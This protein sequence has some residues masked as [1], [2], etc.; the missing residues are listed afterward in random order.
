MDKFYSSLIIFIFYVSARDIF[1]R[2]NCI[3]CLCN[4]HSGLLSL[5]RHSSIRSGDILLGVIF[6]A[7]QCNGCR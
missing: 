3:K 2:P 7:I 5:I 6:K 1:M 4:V